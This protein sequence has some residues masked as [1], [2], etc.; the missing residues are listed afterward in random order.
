LTD[1]VELLRRL[2]VSLVS[3]YMPPDVARWL[4]QGVDAY[5]EGRRL[6]SALGLKTGPG[7]PSPPAQIRLEQ[8]DELVCRLVRGLPGSVWEQAG[9]LEK[10]IADFK[11]ENP[12]RTMQGKYIAEADRLKLEIPKSQAQ[13]YRILNGRRD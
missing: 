4:S 10:I 5:L 8:R 7:K 6:E 3:G 12:I 13:L 1:P 2:Q 11:P 9:T